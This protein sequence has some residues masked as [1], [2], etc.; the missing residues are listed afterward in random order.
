MCLMLYMATGV[1]EPLQ[2]SADLSVENVERT[3]EIV[4]QWFSLPHVYFVGAHGG[5]SCGFPSVIAETPVPYFEG[6]FH[7][8]P[9]READLRSVKSLIALVRRLTARSG[10]VQLYPVADG[11]EHLAPKGRIDVDAESLEPRTFFFNEQFLY[12]VRQHPA[13]GR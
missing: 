5:C 1:E 4:R 8:A 2:K 13:P 11:S 7:D 6:F 10:H 3:R 12:F 9:D